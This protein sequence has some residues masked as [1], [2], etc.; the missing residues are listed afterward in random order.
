LFDRLEQLEE[1]NLAPSS[2]AAQP[3]EVKQVM[4]E[5]NKLVGLEKIKELVWEIKAFVQIQQ[6]RKQ[7]NLKTESVVLHMIF[8]GNPGTGKTTVARILGKLFKSLG[9]LEEGHLKEVERA[10]LV[11]EYVG[12]TAKQTQEAIEEAVGGVLFIDEAYS[13]ARGGEK[14][15]GKEAIDTLVKALEDKREELVIILAGYPQEMETFLQ[16]NP[17]LESR[18]PLQIEFDDYTIKELIKIARQMAQEREYELTDRAETKLYSLLSRL[19]AQGGIERGNAR[20]V[21]NI[22]EQAVRRQAIRLVDKK[23]TINRR[24]LMILNREDFK[25]LALLD[26]G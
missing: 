16:S 13:L 3:E 26:R 11:G 5:L 21:R 17:G 4:A 22:I 6:Q 14:D 20:T 15:F 12:H 25:E 2:T 8:K 18:F 23:E 9:V 10:D 7:H 1:D 24:E 19:R